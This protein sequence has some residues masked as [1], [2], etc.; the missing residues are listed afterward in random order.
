ME[1]FLII[2]NIDAENSFL[3]RL[4]TTDLTYNHKISVVENDNSH[5][6]L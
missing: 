1:L 4:D 5:C 6:L 3:K 2:L